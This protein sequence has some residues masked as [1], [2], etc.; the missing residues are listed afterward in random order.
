M[1]KPSEANSVEQ[2][3]A[4]LNKERRIDLVALDKLIK[5][6]VPSL[7]PWFSNTMPSYGEFKYKDYKKQ[8]GKWPV[9]A[10]A[11]QKN[12][13]SLYVCAI[14]DQNKGQYL[15]DKYEKVLYKNGVKPNIGKS[16]IRFK[17]LEDLN[18]SMLKKL[19]LEAEKTPGMVGV[20]EK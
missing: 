7:K 11:S 17:K 10:L 4:M 13:M 18:V 6:T 20:K 5:E 3:F 15:A 14:N 2:Y 8:P 12:Y 19:L 16:C 9:V 1:F